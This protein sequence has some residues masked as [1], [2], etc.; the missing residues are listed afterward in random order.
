MQEYIILQ[1][2]SNLPNHLELQLQTQ[3]EGYTSWASNVTKRL[4]ALYKEHYTQIGIT[5]KKQKKLWELLAQMLNEE[6]NLNIAA[7]QVENKWRTLLRAYKVITDNN[8]KTG[9]G[10]RVFEYQ[11][12]MD[13][14][15]CKKKNINPE[16]LL[17]NETIA[18]LPKSIT[19][20]VT[21]DEEKEN[22]LGSSSNPETQIL[23][24][25]ISK[26]EIEPGKSIKRKRTLSRNDV[27]EKMRLD[28]QKQHEEMMKKIEERIQIEK[29]RLAER[30]RQNDIQDKR[31]AILEKYLENNIPLL[32]NI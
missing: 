11:E 19:S 15:F 24:E 30:K 26:I 27:L 13:S 29:G 16:V 23:P 8:N 20:D 14:L 2:Q 1:S 25:T 5:I 17:S 31:N 32:K 6:F 3:P 9:R 7:S 18:A 21:K 12:E 28:K 10:R 22:A 4:I